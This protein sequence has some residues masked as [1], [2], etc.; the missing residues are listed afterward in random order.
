MAFVDVPYKDPPYCITKYNM[1]TMHEAF[2][3]D[4]KGDDIVKDT[5]IKKHIAEAAGIEVD[6][7]SGKGSGKGGEEGKGGKGKG[8]APSNNFMGED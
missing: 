5:Y 6:T 3:T 8:D 1:S 7:P 4:A 2:D